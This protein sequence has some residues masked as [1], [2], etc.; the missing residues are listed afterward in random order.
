MLLIIKHTKK[1]QHD[2]W[3]VLFCV[4]KTAGK[5]TLVNKESEKSLDLRSVEDILCNLMDLVK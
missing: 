1:N 3:L 4:V 5:I 2:D